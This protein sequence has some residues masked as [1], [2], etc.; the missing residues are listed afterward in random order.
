MIVTG[1]LGP[2]VA[3][4]LP[5]GCVLPNLPATPEPAI[6]RGGG[7]LVPAD[8]R[9]AAYE[10]APTWDPRYGRMGA[11]LRN[12]HLE[13]DE[14][15]ATDGLAQTVCS[16]AFDSFE[17]ATPRPWEV[18]GEPLL[19][20]PTE[21]GRGCFLELEAPPDGGTHGL[22]REVPAEKVRGEVVRVRVL[23]RLT[24]AARARLFGSP[25]LRWRV[26]TTDGRVSTVALPLV[27]RASPGWEAQESLTWFSGSVQ[28]VVLELVHVRTSG[29][30]AFDDLVVE[31]PAAEQFDWTA[32]AGANPLPGV[33]ARAPATAM[34]LVANGNFE[35]GPKGF[36]VWAE[37]QWPG[38]GTYVVPQYWYFDSDAKVGQMS[39]AVP[40][41]GARAA[42]TVGPFDLIRRGRGE[43]PAERYHLSF[44]AKASA[45]A[46]IEVEWR[47]DGLPA[48]V[49]R[50]PVGTE[51]VRHRHVSLTPYVLVS[52]PDRPVRA[53]LVFRLGDSSSAD[54]V[55]FWLDGVSMGVSSPTER[56]VPPAPVEVGIFGPAPDP[57][58][59]GE[60]LQPGDPAV[61][62]VR[63]AN[64]VDRTYTGSVALDVVDAGDRPVWT[65]TVQP[66]VQADR[67][68]NEQ[69]VLRLP[70][71]YYRVKAAAWSE[72]VG[73]SSILS[74]DERAFAVVDL[75]DPV[76]RAGF[77][78]L[79]ADAGSVSLRTTQ[80][81]SG[82]VGMPLD[83]QWC[84]T[85]EGR[86]SFAGWLDAIERCH[87]QD[88][89]IVA[90]LSGIP[91]EAPRRR[92]LYRAWMDACPVGVAG[93][94]IDRNDASEVEADVRE[95]GFRRVRRWLGAA[96]TAPPAV[97]VAMSAE[98][99]ALPTR[100]AG[101][102]TTAPDMPAFA[103]PTSA[104]TQAPSVMLDGYSFRCFAPAMMPEL[105]E[106]QLDQWARV[107]Q[108]TEPCGWWDLFVIGTAGSAYARRA[109]IVTDPSSPVVVQTPQ[110]DPL[111]SASCLVRS[112][113]IR[114]LA[115]ADYAC[116][117]VH[118]LRTFDTFLDPPE[119]CLSEYDHS[120][121]P[122]LVAWDWMTALLGDAVPIRWFDK[123]SDA[124][125]FVF[126]KGDAV[127]PR[128]GGAMVAAVWRPF[129]RSRQR[130]VLAGLAGKARLYDLFGRPEPG[131]TAGADLI[132]Q[133]DE[134]VRYIV[135]PAELRETLL[136][137][138]ES[139]EP[140]Y[141]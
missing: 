116:S 96:D 31:T 122:A 99:V 113:L 7:Q 8:A 110:A 26:T 11:F 25:Q 127:G 65:K 10:P 83:L 24:S 57:T 75:T 77:Y 14:A 12:R 53:E 67:T 134:I 140:V 114:H 115:N 42:V 131:A 90:K 38:R 70:R 72:S 104:P 132:V 19:R 23:T 106:P 98:A 82:W 62:A 124:R 129:G 126:A 39:L 58:D 68:W 29:A 73:S 30:C 6:E 21:P 111:R 32:V 112:M 27:G 133:I 1:I 100:P 55:I 93:V 92:D 125:V 85:P 17:P 84:I 74:R 87:A 76:P 41:G 2:A 81:G 86:A 28:R 80:I 66:L 48:H 95:D 61:F 59:L 9:E 33:R 117:T 101:A 71:G 44:C 78:G 139:A 54:R 69:I 128:A 130:L 4:A 20:T 121:R 135:A 119:D 22:C 137:A 13:P 36:S 141:P 5:C 51:W 123:P 15:L 79:S 138:L 64:Y 60:L 45:A 34:N 94:H 50:F 118:A 43:R 109:R 47:I 46:Q 89:N 108:A 97:L 102:P 91:R 3:A 52:G 105:A 136:S 88:L 40:V 18:V 103:F 56:Y 63:V 107:R 16:E 120:P 35:V 37:R 49:D